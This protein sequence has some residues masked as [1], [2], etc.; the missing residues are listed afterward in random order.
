MT[1][2]LLLSEI[3]KTSC[4]LKR[5][6]KR[7]DKHIQSIPCIMETKYVNLQVSIEAF[8]VSSREDAVEL[9][10]V[11]NESKYLGHND[12]YLPSFADCYLLKNAKFNF[13]EV[14]IQ[15]EFVVRDAKDKSFCKDGTHGWLSNY[16]N[17]AT[18][19]RVF[20]VRKVS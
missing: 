16:S 1:K 19:P 2:E 6:Q 14:D 3:E 4:E 12:W 20:F 13:Y 11:S 15:K 18:L 9:L 8:K 7:L 10:K 17:K 5:L